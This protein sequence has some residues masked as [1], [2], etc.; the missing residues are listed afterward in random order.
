MLCAGVH[1][2]PVLCDA[3]TSEDIRVRLKDKH[4]QSTIQHIDSSSNSATVTL[5]YTL[6]AA[7]DTCS[8]Q[9]FNTSAVAGLEEICAE[10]AGVCC[11]H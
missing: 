7:S 6:S 2:K 3:A 4:L 8:A 9:R 11:R 10:H 1:L 5:L